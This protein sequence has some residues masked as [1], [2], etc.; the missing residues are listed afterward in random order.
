MPMND[1]NMI[2]D[3]LRIQNVTFDNTSLICFYNDFT[4]GE[5]E[6]RQKKKRLKF[7]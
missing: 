6:H 5:E 3:N 2:D 4:T 1:Y 7:L